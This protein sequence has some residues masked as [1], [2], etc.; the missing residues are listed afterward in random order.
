MPRCSINFSSLAHGFSKR[1]SDAAPAPSRYSPGLVSGSTVIS[2]RRGLRPGPDLKRALELVE[3]DFKARDSNS[4]L[5]KLWAIGRGKDASRGLRSPVLGP[6]LGSSKRR[7][8]NEYELA[9]IARVEGNAGSSGEKQRQWL[10][11]RS[12]GSLSAQS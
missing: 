10:K 12:P 9:T 4:S 2:I 5:G 8:R 1:C 3:E 6:F 11:K 7:R